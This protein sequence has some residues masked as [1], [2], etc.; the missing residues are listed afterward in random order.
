MTLTYEQCRDRI[1]QEKTGRT[2]EKYVQNLYNF[3]KKVGHTDEDLSPLFADVQGLLYSI[4]SM[5]N[6]P[7]TR[8]SYFATMNVIVHAFFNSPENIKI[9]KL[10]NAIE[11]DKENTINTG[12]RVEAARPISEAHEIIA[13]L[14][15]LYA[16]NID[17][18][19]KKDYDVHRQACVF[20]RICLDYG[21]MRPDEWNS[22]HVIAKSGTFH[23][24]YIDLERR[25]VVIRKHKTS[26]GRPEDAREFMISRELV[27]LLKPA[28]GGVILPK[29]G[30]RIDSYASSTGLEKRIRAMTG[31]HSIYDYRRAKT[32]V[33]LEDF[34]TGKVNSIVYGKFAKAQGHSYGTQLQFYNR[35]SLP[36]PKGLAAEAAAEEEAPEAAESSDSE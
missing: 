32:S 23:E 26:K 15:K 31:G 29:L 34:K 5:Y 6:T 2:A 27:A 21:V 18:I 12:R 25:R 20:A 11:F 10:S 28:A 19:S 24:N 22:L 35:Y 33:M 9:F 13:S 3:I 1:R 14:E 30:A 16:D 4:V 17:L 7:S 36:A 8:R